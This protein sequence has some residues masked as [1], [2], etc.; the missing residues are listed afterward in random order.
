MTGDDLIRHV[1][2]LL[3]AEAAGD[4]PPESAFFALE[5]PLGRVLHRAIR[6]L[7]SEVRGVYRALGSKD[8]RALV[9]DRMADVR[10]S[11]EEIPEREDDDSEDDWY[12]A[13]T[14]TEVAAYLDD[15]AAFAARHPDKLPDDDARAIVARLPR[16]FA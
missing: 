2:E 1:R 9:T 8:A 6:N 11:I 14:P 4:P 16:S 13:L 7:A 10:A 15:P 5:D 12:D 3:S